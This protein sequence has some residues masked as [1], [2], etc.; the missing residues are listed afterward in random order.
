MTAYQRENVLQF[1]KIL[2]DNFELSHNEQDTVDYL[3]RILSSGQVIM[4]FD[5][6]EQLI[7]FLDYWRLEK[8]I[9]KDEKPYP[10]EF[11]KGPVLYVNTFWIASEW[12]GKGL[13]WWALRELLS[14]NEDAK[15]L[16][17]NHE[18]RS[19]R[20]FMKKLPSVYHRSYAANH[21]NC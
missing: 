14:R 1:I 15:Y 19:D 7:L 8:L 6:N 5:E 4:R 9:D 12:E 17:W 11:S 13:N 20:F 21:R 18:K 16:A 10:K 2:K 3:E